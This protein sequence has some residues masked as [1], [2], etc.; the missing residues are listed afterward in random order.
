MIKPCYNLVGRLIYHSYTIY[1]KTRA[2]TKPRSRVVL[3]SATGQIFLVKNWIGSGNWQLPGGRINKQEN[4]RQAAIREIKEELGLKLSSSQLS[5]I[6][7]ENL[8]GSLSIYHCQLIGQ[9]TI[10]YNK[11]EIIAGQWFKPHQLTNLNLVD[12]SKQALQSCQL[13]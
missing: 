6:A 8:S 9:P 7:A 12:S 10:N 13:L 4:P 3:Q 5:P 11:K 1:F 2:I